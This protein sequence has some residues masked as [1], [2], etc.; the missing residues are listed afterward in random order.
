MPATIIDG[1]KIAR[2]VREAVAAEAASL[3][4]EHGIVPGLAVV[5]VGEDPA[6]QVYV[7]MKQKACEEAGIRSFDHRL[8]DA[9]SQQEALDLVARLN[10]DD[11]VHGIL[12]QLPLPARIDELAVLTSIDPD[13][14]IDGFHPTNLG[15]LL[16]G[17][18]RF[19][20][21][22]PL[23]VQHM[24]MRS[25]FDPAGKHVVIVG[26]SN[27][28]GKPLA[29]ILCQKSPGG[30]ATVSL[31]HSFTA[32]LAHQTRQA[33]IL[34]A[35]MGRPGAISAEMVRDGA[36]VIDVGVNRIEDAS[37]P[38]GTR[39]VGDVDFD[40]VAAKAA[41]I[42]PVPGGV[43]PMTIAMLLKNTLTAA[44]QRRHLP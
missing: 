7:R 13:K 2:E 14:D 29:A 8:P 31:C 30:N 6:S 10:E 40:A 12:V 28:V 38:R 9:A 42:T 25:G 18:P 34:I 24:L 39:L 3:R 15:L 4:K 23:G 16:I 32:D 26:R 43:G 35:A 44:K 22:T 19:V 37:S 36:V 27:I 1:A 41:A 11:A 20:P 17:K 21:C 5:L 33:D